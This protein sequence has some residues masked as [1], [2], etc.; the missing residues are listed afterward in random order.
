MTEIVAAAAGG[1][2]GLSY[3]LLLSGLI[4]AHVFGLALPGVRRMYAEG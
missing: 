2:R 3:P 1:I 4:A